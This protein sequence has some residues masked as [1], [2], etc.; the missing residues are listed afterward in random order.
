MGTDGIEAM[1]A[2]RPESQ[3]DGTSFPD[4]WVVSPRQSR[5]DDTATPMWEEIRY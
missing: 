1:T 5:A 4:S 3:P 2:P